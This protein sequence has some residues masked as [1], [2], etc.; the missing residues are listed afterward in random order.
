V[1]RVCGH[2]LGNTRCCLGIIGTGSSQPAD[3]RRRAGAGQRKKWLLRDARSFTYSTFARPICICK[4]QREHVYTATR[5]LLLVASPFVG[6]PQ[7][8]CVTSRAEA[9]IARRPPTFSP[10]L[11]ALS[12]DYVSVSA[13]VSLAVSVSAR[14]S[15]AVSVSARVGLAVVGA[16]VG[17]W[18]R[19]EEKARAHVL[20]LWEWLAG[21]L[22]GGSSSGPLVLAGG[23]S[24]EKCLDDT[25]VPVCLLLH[26]HHLLPPN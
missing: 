17:W 11:D 22:V 4:R 16:W 9:Q 24:I 20:W 10:R 18:A 15:L 12:S 21:W 5:P 25:T 23:R 19:L 7:D 3:S 1:T 8:D 13:R 14:V 26:N 2:C 6:G